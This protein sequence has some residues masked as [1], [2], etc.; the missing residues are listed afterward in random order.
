MCGPSLR[1]DPHHGAALVS[2]ND[3][4]PGGLAHNAV[5]TG[6]LGEQLRPLGDVPGAPSGNLLVRRD[7]DVERGLQI[8]R[9]EAS[10]GRQGRGERA[11]HI[12]GTPTEQ[13]TASYPGLE[14]ITDPAVL[15]G[16]G[17]C[18]VV[19]HQAKAAPALAELADDGHLGHPVN[20]VVA[21]L[22]DLAT[23]GAEE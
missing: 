8:R 9:F 11:L 1:R 22:L 16:G 13:L 10:G 23:D 3:A 7:D 17:N 5:A 12:A 15:P 2:V 21:Q 6:C 14:W 4:Q 19:A 20:V 18:I